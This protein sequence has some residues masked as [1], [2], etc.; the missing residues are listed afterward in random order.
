MN[1]RHCL[2]VAEGSG[3]GSDRLTLS[4]G[5]QPQSLSHDPPMTLR[6][7]VPEELDAERWDG[8]TVHYSPELQNPR[9]KITG[10]DTRTVKQI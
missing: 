1:G 9:R 6:P 3:S 5:V 4:L 8:D 10:N 7:D 2:H